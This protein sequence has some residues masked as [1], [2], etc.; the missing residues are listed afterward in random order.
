[1]NNKVVNEG[2]RYQITVPSIKFLK[3]G[4]SV[5][6]LL[7]IQPSQHGF[8]LL[9][10]KS[11]EL[12]EI[13]VGCDCP[14]SL[15]LIGANRVFIKFSLRH[16]HFHYRRAVYLP[17]SFMRHGKR[18]AGG[19]LCAGLV[20][21]PD[22]EDYGDS[23]PRQKGTDGYDQEDQNTTLR[24]VWHQTPSNYDHDQGDEKEMIHRRQFTT[25]DETLGVP[26]PKKSGRGDA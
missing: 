3:V 21:A 20:K 23:N 2:I 5:L 6:Q 19:R 22:D 8:G 11:Y 12:A 24:L 25:P 10:P 18:D 16:L 14:K 15:Q 17:P 9:I 26:S 1:M 4:F 13:H 7:P